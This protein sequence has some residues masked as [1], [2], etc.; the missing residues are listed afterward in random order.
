MKNTTKFI[1]SYILFLLVAIVLRFRPTI[2]SFL[3]NQQ[4]MN[5]ASGFTPN[6][7]SEQLEIVTLA[8]LTVLT[9][10]F[11]LILIYIWTRTSEV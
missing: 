5:V 4:Y 8:V 10:S 7:V 3:L 1:L 11:G 6:A 9:Y 2:S